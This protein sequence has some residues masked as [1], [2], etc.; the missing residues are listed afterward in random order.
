M[1]TEDTTSLLA[2]L[3][4]IHLPEAPAEP[5][6]WPLV[7]ATVLCLLAIAA[8][9]YR[10]SKSRTSWSQEA[11]AELDSIAEKR[12]KISDGPDALQQT[13]ALLKRIVLTHSSDSSVKHLTG[14]K[15]LAHLDQFFNTRYFSAGDGQI[16]GNTLYQQ[17]GQASESLYQELKKLIRKRKWQE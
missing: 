7:I 5:P 11:L 16:F 9:F 17:D 2:Q 10:R 12:T 6:V 3:R 8:I 1:A 13:A 15:W 14:D 4:D